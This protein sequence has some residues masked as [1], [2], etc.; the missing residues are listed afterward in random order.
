MC[1]WRDCVQRTFSSVFQFN[2][3]CHIKFIK[4]SWNELLTTNA[5]LFQIVRKCL[6][7][8]EWAGLD[9]FL[10]IRNGNISASHNGCS[11]PTEHFTTC[12][13]NICC[14]VLQKLFS[15]GEL[16][17]YWFVKCPVSLRTIGKLILWV[18]SVEFS[19]RLCVLNNLQYY[20][21]KTRPFLILK[22]R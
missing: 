11:I 22:R 9:R 14:L 19:P 12:E 3:N 16:W 10:N 7:I 2:F 18:F 1:F 21:E 17:G 20:A 8:D 4:C 15:I 5:C 6:N 13:T